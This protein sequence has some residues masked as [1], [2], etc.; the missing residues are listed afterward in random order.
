VIGDQGVQRNPMPAE[1]DRKRA[2]RQAQTTLRPP[3]SV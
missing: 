3:D 2:E 1:R